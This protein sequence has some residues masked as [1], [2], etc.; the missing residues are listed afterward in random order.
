[1]TPRDRIAAARASIDARE[2]EIHAWAHLDWDAVEEQVSTVEAIPEHRRGPLWGMPV[3]VKDIYDT[4]DFP[5]GEGSPIY[6]NHRPKGD[7]ACVAVLRAAG[8]IILGKTVTTEL[9]YFTQGP[10]RH[11]ANPAHSPGGSSSGSAAA[12]AAGMVP[13][14]VGSQTAGSVC[15]PA[16]FCGVVGFKPTYGLIPLAGTKSFSPSL[17]T[18]G[19]FARSVAEVA[20]MA[21]IMTRNDWQ[22][23]PAEQPP[24]LARFGGP[25]REAATPAALAAV[26]A[27]LEGLPVGEARR[28]APFADLIDLQ[29]R[30]MRFEM[31]RESEWEVQT[32]F[33]Q[34]SPAYQQLMHDG[35]AITAATY[36]EDRATLL[37]TKAAIDDLFGDAEILVQ[38]SAPGE[39]PLYEDGTGDPVMNRAWTLLGLPAI[40]IPCGTGPA[41]LPLGLQLA[42]RPH[43]DK[44]LLRVAA[45]FERQ[46]SGATV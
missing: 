12:V 39:A 7:A 32:A 34:L 8:A 26:D 3:G 33:E 44:S 27:A 9:A 28:T 13:L 31:R 21:G 18:A 46:L 19:V 38:P 1:M 41:G 2:A 23:T 43:R 35:E 14:A 36:A 17:D 15:R 22:G 29:L 20:V 5:T 30:I 16:S 42:A 25:E 40:S 4:G 10:T 11:P 45:W 37:K 6:A 24:R